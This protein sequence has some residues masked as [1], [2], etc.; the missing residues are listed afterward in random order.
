LTVQL[1]PTSP[2]RVE[3][4]ALHL[5]AAG[6][7]L[8]G[9]GNGDLAANTVEGRVTL[10]VPDLAVASGL[11]KAPLQGR[12]ALSLTA[13]GALKQPEVDLTLDAGGLSYDT[14]G[15]QQLAVAL[16]MK[17][18][19][20][21]ETTFPGATLTGNASVAGVSQG[22]RPVA[23]EG[24]QGT[25]LTLDLAAMAPAEGPIDIQKALLQALGTQASVGGQ[26]DPERMAGRLRLDL[27]VPTLRPL[28]A[29]AIPD[30]N[31][32]PP[33]DG[34][35]DLG[36]D[37]TIGEGAGTIDAVLA[38][39][40]VA[41]QGLPPGAAELLGREP[42]FDLRASLETGRF[43]QISTLAFK[44]AAI[45]LTGKGTLQLAGEETFA[46][47]LDLEL[48][49][50][51]AASGLAGQ[52]LSGSLAANVKASGSMSEPNVVLATR[53]DRLKGA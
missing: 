25:L 37:I 50:L 36:S 9:Q 12:A 35:I 17:L 47:D 32:R 28:V 49:R 19:A 26:F 39:R 33:I 16:Q 46:A 8:E 6:F 38:L 21:F 20:P 1:Q 45:D 3:L 11:A 5:G 2:Q 51:A 43:V 24:A 44:G 31:S 14:Y 29:S 53:I 30:Q 18:L 4:Q 23:P 48:P 13:T 34:K 10:E 40:T 42:R 41:L 27:E 52:P 15:V 22:G 7:G